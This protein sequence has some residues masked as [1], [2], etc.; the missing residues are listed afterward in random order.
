MDEGFEVIKVSD[1]RNNEV[2]IDIYSTYTAVIVNTQ[3]NESVWGP[4]MIEK[5]RRGEQDAPI[6]VL[7]IGG[8]WKRHVSFIHSGANYFLTDPNL[9]IVLAYLRELAKSKAPQTA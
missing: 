9:E 4:D 6:I 2:N 3:G 7:E 8:D 5:L 1:T